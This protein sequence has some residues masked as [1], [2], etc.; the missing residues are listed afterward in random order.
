MEKQTRQS[1]P[2]VDLTN[3]Q[4]GYLTPMYY[5][6]GGKWHCK[7]KCGNEIDVDT[8]NLNSGHTKSCGCL[9]KEKASLNVKDMIGY[10]SEYLKVLSRAGSDNQ[11]AALWNCLCKRC[12]NTF[13][14]R[15]SSIR[16][17]YVQGCGCVHSLN[18]QNIAQ[19][20]T[21]NH[22]EFA[23]QYT[24]PDLIGINGG[25]LRFD[26]AIFDSNHILSHLI[27]YNGEQHYIQPL[28]SWEK[29]F[30]TLQ[31]HDKI[32]QEYCKKHNIRLIVIPYTQQ[33][34]ISDLL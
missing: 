18:E 27:E 7:C 19:L 21:Q 26:F 16:A 20:L 5:I 9:I 8:R 32:K 17:G 31:E 33:Y 23:T 2:R 10:E 30:D 4:F 11:G 22:I 12:G 34:T 6:K 28:G 15:G 29:G 3:K 25:H 14:T 24:F 1:K 13:I